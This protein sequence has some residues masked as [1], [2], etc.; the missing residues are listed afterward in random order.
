M[1]TALKLKWTK[2]GGDLLKH[3]LNFFSRINQSINQ[4]IFNVV[5]DFWTQLYIIYCN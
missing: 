4:N 5:L 3:F 2:P 1:T